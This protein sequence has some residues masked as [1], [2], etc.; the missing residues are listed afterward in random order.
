MAPSDNLAHQTASIIS[1]PSSAQ[2]AMIQGDDRT[3]MMQQAIAASGDLVYNVVLDQSAHEPSRLTLWA[4]GD[5]YAIL[6]VAGHWF[7]GVAL[8]SD[9]KGWRGLIH[10]HDLKNCEELWDRAAGDLPEDALFYD[11]EYRLCLPEG[12]IIWI[13]DRGRLMP[14]STISIEK[15]YVLKRCGVIRVITR[16]KEYQQELERRA[17]IDEVTGLPNRTALRQL[18]AHNHDDNIALLAVGVDNLS[19]FLEGFGQNILDSLI[20]GVARFLANHLVDGEMVGRM[21][22][23]VFGLIL[24]NRSAEQI[25]ML[26]QQLLQDIRQQTMI[27]E[28]GSFH[29]SFSIGGLMVEETGQTPY[30][31]MT[32]V[33]LALRQA[34]GRGGDCYIQ[35]RWSPD[36]GREHRT[37]MVIC[38][39]VFQAMKTGRTAFAFQPIVQAD[40]LQTDYYECLLRLEDMDG[41]IVAA[42]HFMPAVEKLGAARMIDQMVLEMTINELVASPN[43]TLSMNISGLTVSDAAWAARLQ[44]QLGQRP[45]MAERLIIEITETVAMQD[46]NQAAAFVSFV[47]K[48]GCRVA[49]DDFG[50]GYTSFQY[51]QMLP[52][53]IVKID[54]SFVRGLRSNAQNL[55]FIKSLVSL[56]RGLNKHLVV[57]GVEQ[58]ADADILKAEGVDFFQGMLFGSPMMER[59]WRP[60]IK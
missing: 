19:S 45:Q 3:G 49:L 52:I 15:D 57:E 27:T 29:T 23:D 53:D 26:A 36:G 39:Q 31:L 2:R 21:S 51:L 30:A 38:E 12:K 44:Q 16:D 54:R 25:S 37:N 24:K 8:P 6:A 33:E 11:L 1:Y 22:S 14:D 55:L 50:T 60:N 35:Y 18:L 46:V 28:A 42:G 40:S 32:K 58:Q 9:E 5:V 41:R 4:G 13:N 59:P 34:R 48:L 10:P 56:A 43:I 17:L 20:Q 47:K 7:D